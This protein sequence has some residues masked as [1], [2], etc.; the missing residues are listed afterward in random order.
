[1]SG[2]RLHSVT[3][4]AV[5]TL[6]IAE[7]Y[8]LNVESTV[9][10]AGVVFGAYVFLHPR[11]GDALRRVALLFLPLAIAGGLVQSAGIAVDLE[12]VWFRFGA[13]AFGP[14]RA[15]ALAVTCARMV[16]VLA[17]GL[18]AANHASP[19]GIR[20][21]AADFRFPP[22]VARV[23]LSARGFVSLARQNSATVIEAQ[24]LRGLAVRGSF[25]ERAQALPAVI[26]PLMTNL[27]V[28][29]AHRSAALERRGFARYD[30]ALPRP[31]RIRWS[32]RLVVI[33]C[34]AL[35]TYQLLS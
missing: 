32:D 31:Q 29:A 33:S 7:T 14:E 16:T 30:G 5:G 1:M 11:R 8:L 19:R 6:C 2:V 25:L 24:S 26:V 22:A 35:V 27:F 9:A 4:V 13:F 18:S 10:V 17:L 23:L 28:E 12:I 20:Q 15:R 34:L 21:F 3:W